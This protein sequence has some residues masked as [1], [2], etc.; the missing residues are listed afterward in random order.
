MGRKAI[1]TIPFKKLEMY[2]CTD[3]REQTLVYQMEK[4]KA[5]VKCQRKYIIKTKQI[6]HLLPACQ[7]RKPTGSTNKSTEV[8]TGNTIRTKT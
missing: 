6:M 8:L 2:S 7:N 5:Q 1:K 4:T 3:D